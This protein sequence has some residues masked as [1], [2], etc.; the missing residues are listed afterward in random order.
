MGRAWVEGSP[1]R[2]RLGGYFT[3]V[4]MGG[5]GAG[6][7]IGE[8]GSDGSGEPIGFS[9]ELENRFGT[10]RN[11]WQTER[12]NEVAPRMTWPKAEWLAAGKLLRDCLGE[13]D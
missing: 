6:V 12:D 4:I 1:N 10:V 5:S 2:E 13:A 9:R 8:P 7:G 3:A 11:I